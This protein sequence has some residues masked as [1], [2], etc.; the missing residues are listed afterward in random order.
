MTRRCVTCDEPI[1]YH[2]DR[3]TWSHKKPGADHAPRVP[4]R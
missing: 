3:F 1:V 2:A 4:Q